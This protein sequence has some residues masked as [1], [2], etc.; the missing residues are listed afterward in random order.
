MSI[1]LSKYLSISIY[2][3]I[4]MSCAEASKRRAQRL[5]RERATKQVDIY[6]ETSYLENTK[7]IT[8]TRLHL[9]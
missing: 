5:E 7:D 6:T 8:I 9:G 4:Y 1:Y 2:I 3:Y